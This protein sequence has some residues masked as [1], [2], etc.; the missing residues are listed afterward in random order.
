[1]S[2]FFLYTLVKYLMYSKT[3][4]QSNEIPPKNHIDFDPVTTVRY[5]DSKE[6]DDMSKEPESFSPGEE[7]L[8]DIEG[9]LKKDIVSITTVINSFT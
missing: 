4:D 3:E 8:Q 7:L 6:G 5:Y 9:R 2:L 1:M